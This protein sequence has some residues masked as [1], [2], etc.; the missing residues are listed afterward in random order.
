[1]YHRFLFCLALAL[2]VS[3]Q[4]PAPSPGKWEKEILAFEANDRTNAPLAGAILFVGSSSIRY[5]TNLAETFPEWKTVRRGFGGAYLSDVNAYFD[6]LILPYKPK[7]IVLYAGENDIAG[8]RSA[9]EVFSEFKA[10]IEKVR[11]HF[12]ECAVYYLSMKPSPSR[13]FL[14]PQIQEGNRL[15]K[16]FTDRYSRVE[17]VDVGSSLMK[18]G[19]PDEKLFEKD[20]LHITQGGYEL[21]AREIRRAVKN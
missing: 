12:P 1:M 17:F 3:A 4:V 2:C 11:E 6:R 5:W 16:R 8:G 15:I 20:R 10:F 9:K 14:W 18:D 19:L 21:W 7:T 13:W